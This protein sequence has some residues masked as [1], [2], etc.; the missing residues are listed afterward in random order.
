MLREAV[1][2]AGIAI[3]V[4]GGGEIALERLASLGV[5][6]RGRFGLGGNDALLLLEDPVCELAPRRFRPRVRPPARGRHRPAIAHP[7]RNPRV[8]EEPTI[9]ADVV[10][11]GAVIQLTAA[12]IDGRVGRLAATCSRRLLELELAHCIASDA[13]DPGCAMWG[14]RTPLQRSAQ[15]SSDR[16]SS[17]TSRQHCSR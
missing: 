12:S 8:Q 6:P 4:R 11:A 7:E 3:D 1:A 2:H 13:Q 9:L 15:A 10:R 17:R 14:S 5:G 16:G